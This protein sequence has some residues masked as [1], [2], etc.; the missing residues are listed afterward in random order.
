MSLFAVLAWTQEVI[1]MVKRYSF[2]EYGYWDYDENGHVV[3]AEPYDKAIA[4]I[5]ELEAENAKT[6]TNLA[7]AIH[8]E[9]AVEAQ[10]EAALKKVDAARNSL[11]DAFDVV[12]VLGDK[13]ATGRGV[14]VDTPLTPTET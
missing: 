8:N 10:L 4:R 12:N 6:K 1:E 14:I 2:D 7:L 3:D 5:A 9:A 13:A 11:D